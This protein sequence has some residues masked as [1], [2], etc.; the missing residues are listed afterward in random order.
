MTEQRRQLVYAGTIKHNGQFVH[1]YYPIESNG[2]M[3]NRAMTYPRA[4]SDHPVG[5]VCSFLVNNRNDVFSEGVMYVNEWP[6][7][8]DV[9]RWLA[10]HDTLRAHASTNGPDTLSQAYACLD[11][12]RQAYQRVKEPELQATLLAQVVRYI[13]ET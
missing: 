10:T 12:I 5:S 1:A 2:V 4:L 7:K 8:S 13:V 6:I 3:A 11:P 9:D